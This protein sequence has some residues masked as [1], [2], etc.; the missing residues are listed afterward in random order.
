MSSE[1]Q[2]GNAGGQQY[3]LVRRTSFGTKPSRGS[4]GSD[5]ARSRGSKCASEGNHNVGVPN[6]GPNELEASSCSDSSS[7]SAPSRKRGAKGREVRPLRDSE[8]VRSLESIGKVNRVFYFMGFTIVAGLLYFWIMK[9]PMKTALWVGGT[10]C[11]LDV[12][13]IIL[14]IFCF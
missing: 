2:G 4:K 7:S 1:Q 14:Y 10:L 3:G 13:A 5:G 12:I 8:V 9:P 11:T 6:S